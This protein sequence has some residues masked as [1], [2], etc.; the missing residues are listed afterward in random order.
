M[1]LQAGFLTRNDFW[2]V[3]QRIPQVHP[4]SVL[5]R[6]TLRTLETL[7]VLCLRPKVHPILPDFGF[8]FSKTNSP[9]EAFATSLALFRPE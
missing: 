4:V 6:D 9:T 2:I 7:Y 1:A 3:S 5:F 8:E